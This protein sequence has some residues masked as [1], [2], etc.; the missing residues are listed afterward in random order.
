MRLLSIEDPVFPE[1]LPASRDAMA[2]SYPEVATGFERH[3]VAGHAPRRRRSASSLRA[4]TTCST[5]R[6]ETKSRGSGV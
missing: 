6:Y 3:L 5:R 4:G 1:L 2:P